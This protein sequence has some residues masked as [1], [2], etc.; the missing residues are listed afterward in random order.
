MIRSLTYSDRL[1]Q[2]TLFRQMFRGRARTFSERLGWNVKV[3]QGMECDRYDGLPTVRYLIA[4]DA[5]ER[6]VGSLRLLPTTGETMLRNEFA[7]YFGELS[8]LEG[9][10]TWE[11]TRFCTHPRAGDSSHAGAAISAELLITLCQFAMDFGIERIVGVYEAP[12]VRVYRRIGWCPRGIARNHS[13]A[14]DLRVGVWDVSRIALQSMKK[15]QMN[16][17]GGP[18]VVPHMA[19]AVGEL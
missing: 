5:A 4:T 11:C 18:I 3:E 7:A 12:M 8:G 9:P 1:Q 10:G 6:V 2:E 19:R 15:A 16:A 14:G 13:E 17:L